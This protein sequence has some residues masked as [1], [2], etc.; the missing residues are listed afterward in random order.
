LDYEVEDGR[1]VLV[2]TEVPKQLGGRGLGGRLVQAGVERA[3]R[4]GLTVAPWCPYARKW[5]RDHPDAIASVV[6]DWS[7]PPA[8]R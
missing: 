1:L 5:L 2:H 4:E 3:A 8:L 7:E 6:V